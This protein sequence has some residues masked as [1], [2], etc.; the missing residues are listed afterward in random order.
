[1]TIL[2]KQLNNIGNCNLIRNG[3]KSDV[4]KKLKKMIK[5]KKSSRCID[6]VEKTGPEKSR[7]INAIV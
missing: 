2:Q 4:F 6:V 7:L 1:M 3:S 5:L